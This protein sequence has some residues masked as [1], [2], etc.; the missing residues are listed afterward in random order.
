[1]HLWRC[2]CCGKP[3]GDDARPGELL[4]AHKQAS[5]VFENILDERFCENI[6]HVLFGVDFY[7]LNASCLHFVPESKIFRSKMASAG[8]DVVAC[9]D[10]KATL[11]VLADLSWLYSV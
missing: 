3:D 10:N 9:G 5:Q 11:I 7:D 6:T 8:F 4:P 1:V 2:D